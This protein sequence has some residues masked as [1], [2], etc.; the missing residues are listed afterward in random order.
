ML[1]LAAVLL[2]SERIWLNP[3]LSLAL[4]PGCS[5]ILLYRITLSLVK[6]NSPGGRELSSQG[7]H[8]ECSR[9]LW[10][11]FNFPCLTL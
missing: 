5:Y 9:T 8:H 11:S 2:E 3:L 6:I 1:L 10:L 4:T 7:T